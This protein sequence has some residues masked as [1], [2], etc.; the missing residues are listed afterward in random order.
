MILGIIVSGGIGVMEL[1]DRCVFC[2][3]MQMLL[4]VRSFRPFDFSDERVQAK[5]Q[6]CRPQASSRCPQTRSRK[7]EAFQCRLTNVPLGQRTCSTKLWQ[8]C[9]G[10]RPYY[11]GF[12][13]VA[14]TASRR[15]RMSQVV[16]IPLVILCL[17]KG[18]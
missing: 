6:C 18:E 3:S 2:R 8:H 15:C 1:G 5:Q 4:Q 9:I 12:L 17:V 11:D 13:I 7:F 16:R 14:Y 10:E